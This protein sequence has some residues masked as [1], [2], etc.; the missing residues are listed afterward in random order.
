MFFQKYFNIIKCL[1]EVL[2]VFF[3]MYCNSFFATAKLSSLENE[4][5]R[6]LLEKNRSTQQL[7]EK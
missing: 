5:Y 3:K 6:Q 4:V 7:F 1:S 2:H